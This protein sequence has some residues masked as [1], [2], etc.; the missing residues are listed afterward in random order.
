M[1]LVNCKNCEAPFL[2][3]DKEELCFNCL[4]QEREQ[5]KIIK[6]FATKAEIGY[7]SLESISEHTHIELTEVEKLYKK[8]LLLGIVDKLEVKCQFCGAELRGRDNKINVCPDCSKEML[9]KINIEKALINKD[10]KLEN[11][12]TTRQNDYSKDKRYGFKKRN[13]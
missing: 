10:I 12:K 3:R 13:D 7:L 11:K 8:G 1:E 9:L 4:M 6:E 5:V 2:K